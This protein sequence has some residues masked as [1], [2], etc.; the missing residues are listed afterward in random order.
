MQ[1]EYIC[2]I[3]HDPKNG[4]SISFPDLPGIGTHVAS[5]DAVATVVYCLWEEDAS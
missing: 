1:H 4:L 3:H 2:V 5:S